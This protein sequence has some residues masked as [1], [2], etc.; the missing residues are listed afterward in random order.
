MKLSCAPT[1]SSM[2]PVMSEPVFHSCRARSY[3]IASHCARICLLLIWSAAT[4]QAQAPVD[5]SKYPTRTIK[6]VVPYPPGAFNDSLARIVSQKL[7]EAWGVSVVVENRPGGGTL[8]GNDLVAKAAPDGYTLLGVAFPFAA[9]PSIYKH[10]PYD[11]LRDFTP[12]LFAGQTPNILV[13]RPSLGV[14]TVV[15]FIA[16]ARQNPGKVSYG[17]AGIGSSN[18]LSMELFRSMTGVDVVHVPYKGSSPM[19][20][21]LLGSH[22]DVAFDNTP[23]VL[24]QVKAGSLLALGVTSKAPSDLA[25]GI[26]TVA[27]SGVP[28]YEVNVWFG[29]VGPAGMPPDIVTKLNSELNAIL[30][31]PDVKQRFAEQGVAP[32]GGPPQQFAD[33]IKA[34]IEKW[35]GVVKDANVPQQ[36]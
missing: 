30:Q 3:C 8:I 11:T 10:L 24:P 27:A 21:D 32:V 9:N 16:Y 4:A 31:M 28:N 13:V 35:A 6:Y 34:E 22:I 12:L 1:L 29:I 19:V 36:E 7:Q 26:A 2:V 17:S 33:H 23:N 18:H 25:P 15:E 5:T 20:S 14:K